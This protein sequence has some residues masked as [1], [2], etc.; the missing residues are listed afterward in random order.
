MELTPF[1]TP[2]LTV[3]KPSTNGFQETAPVD[4]EPPQKQQKYED[5][6]KSVYY[7]LER[8]ETK[9]AIIYHLIN[10]VLIVGSIITSILSTIESYEDNVTLIDLILYYELSLL[11][12]FT[13]EY[14]L[15][16]W[17]CSFLG[18]YKGI[19]GK[20]RFMKTLYM[21]IDAFVI[22]STL[23]TALSLIHI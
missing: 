13:I 2:Q 21:M 12:W 14:V 11:S 8:P 4:D 5:I 9:I 1:S 3:R 17:S 18:K 22:I 20:L 19:F 6:R 7:F 23:T 16:V 15:R 10:L